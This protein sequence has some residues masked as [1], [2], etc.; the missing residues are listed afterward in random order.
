MTSRS[1]FVSQGEFPRSRLVRAS[2]RCHS[3]TRFAGK[4]SAAVR[5][6]AAGMAGSQACSNP[7]FAGFQD[8]TPVFADWLD[9]HFRPTVAAE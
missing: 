7:P 4:S 2:L 5:A 8:L 3:R 9:R 6:S 1:A